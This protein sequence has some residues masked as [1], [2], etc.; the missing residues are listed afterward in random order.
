MEIPGTEVEEV[1]SPRWKRQVDWASAVAWC[2][3]NP[4]QAREVT[5]VHS[6]AAWALRRRYPDMTIVSGNHHFVGPGRRICDVRLVYEPD[7]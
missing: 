3:L 4:G 1:A 6:G 5:G 7:E 2:R